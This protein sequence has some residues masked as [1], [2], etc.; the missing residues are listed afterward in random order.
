MDALGMLSMYSKIINDFVE[1]SG[2]F[3]GIETYQYIIMRPARPVAIGIQLNTLAET[4]Y[5]LLIPK[6]ICLG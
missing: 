2:L 1:K 3:A 5:W 4:E 6:S